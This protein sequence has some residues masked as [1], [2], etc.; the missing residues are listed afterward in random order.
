MSSASQAPVESEASQASKRDDAIQASLSEF[1]DARHDDGPDL[2][3]L[4]DAEREAYDAV[5]LGDFG[6][7]EYARDTSR[8]PGTIGNLLSRAR[9]KLDD[10]R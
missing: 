10:G 3:D 2:S 4:T 8:S 6:V 7:R 5:V 1:A 9:D